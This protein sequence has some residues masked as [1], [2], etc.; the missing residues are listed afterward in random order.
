[1]LQY[2]G[3]PALSGSAGRKKIRG[4][5]G[6]YILV[7]PLG[8]LL[9]LGAASEEKLQSYGAGDAML[10]EDSRLM[11]EALAAIYDDTGGSSERIPPRAAIHVKQPDKGHRPPS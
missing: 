8:L 7:L 2:L 1:M 4:L 10:D 11:D 6:D 3:C 5:A 9:I